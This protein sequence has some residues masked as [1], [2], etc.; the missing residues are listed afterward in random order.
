MN[1]IE[2][3]TLP[4]A[5]IV[6][7]HYNNTAN[8]IELQQQNELI[9]AEPATVEDLSANPIILNTV[10]DI[11]NN[12]LSEED[13]LNLDAI[14]PIL[15]IRN[16]TIKFF[17]IIIF[18]NIIHLIPNPLNTINLPNLVLNIYGLKYINYKIL[19]SL[20]A[21]NSILIAITIIFNLILVFNLSNFVNYFLNNIPHND[22]ILI[23]YLPILLL[24]SSCVV[25][26]YLYLIN[27]F[28]KINVYYRSLTSQQIMILNAIIIR[29]Q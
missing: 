28:F 24:T 17:W 5:E 26:M 7:T 1:V 18:F 19:K 20:I 9:L 2:R 4:I 27:N 29:N 25:F 6:P 21:C 14:K 12:I 8:I 13:R 22:L 23:I 16:S 10:S 11:E 3:T 15:E